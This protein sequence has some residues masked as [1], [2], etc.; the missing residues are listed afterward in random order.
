MENGTPAAPIVF[1]DCWR[2]WIIW[3]NG[4]GLLSSLPKFATGK[5]V[6]CPNEP[7]ISFSLFLFWLPG[8]AS[9]QSFNFQMSGAPGSMAELTGHT[10]ILI[11]SSLT[12]DW[13]SA[14]EKFDQKEYA[15]LSG[16]QWPGK[17]TRGRFAYW[18][19]LEIDTRALSGPVE[20]VLG[21]VR[22]D[23]V[24]CFLLDETGLVQEEM[25][26]SR[27]TNP[28]LQ[29]RLPI[30]HRGDVPLTFLPGKKYRLLV[31]LRTWMSF[32]TNVRPALYNPTYRSRSLGEQLPFYFA[33]HGLFFGTLI[34]MVGYSTVQYFQ[35]RD[36]SFLWYA[37]YLA[38][39]FVFYLREFNGYNPFFKILPDFVFGQPWYM[40]FSFGQYFFYVIF[41]NVF[42]GSKKR[43]PN[44]YRFS[45]MLIIAMLVFLVIERIL[46]HTNEVW[47]WKATI[48]AR[49]IFLFG[50]LY[51][52]GLLMKSLDRL[53]LFI[54]SG[55]MILMLSNLA[56]IILSF[57]KS[58]MWGF[59]DYTHIPSYLGILLEIFLFSTG[60]GYKPRQ[61]EAQKAEAEV[62]ARRL[63]ELG[64]AKSRFFTNLTHEFRTPLTVI[65]GLASEM[66]ARPNFKFAERMGILKRNGREM[67]AL[68]NQLL[69]L[70]RAE[71]GRPVLRPVRDDVIGFLQL[72]VDSFHSHAL[73]Q[74]V[75]L[76]FY[77]EN[78]RLEMDFDPAKMQHI[79]TNLLSNAI[80]FTPEYGKV[81][82]AAKQVVLPQGEWLEIK[83][84]D[85]GVGIS[86]AELPHIFD[87]FYQVENMQAKAGQ[88]T[89]IG[90]ALVQGLVQAMEGEVTVKSTA[91]KG[92]TFVVRLPITR[93][94]PAPNAPLQLPDVAVAERVM[95]PP[96]PAP[97]SV[98]FAAA[99]RSIVLVIE[100]NAEVDYYLRTC[101]E[102]DWEVHTVTR[103]GHGV[104]K[105][106]E[107]LPDVII[108]D[109]MMPGMDGFEVCE[110][111]KSDERTS[112]IPILLLTAKATAADKLEG[113][114]KG[115]DAY[116]LKP[117]DKKEL[118]LRL[119]NFAKLGHN[120]NRHADA[121]AEGEAVSP[122][123]EF[124]EK[125]KQAIHA[126]LDDTNF[127]NDGL[128]RT[129][130]VSRA[131]MH[132]KMK[133]LTGLSTGRFIREYR[134]EQARQLLEDTDLRIGEVARKTGFE[135]LSWFTQAYRE[136]FG[137]SPS[138]TR[139]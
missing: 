114:S 10:A 112:H 47:A 27:I 60:L 50:G 131:Q 115:A 127:G 25:T 8:F 89:G 16:F 68:V 135:N 108:C 120:I 94:A 29:S 139:K 103:G 95:P 123:S 42:L 93:K 118:L 76:Q 132:R 82:V 22:K 48:S 67:L 64:R 44:F 98:H 130:G 73:S 19:A 128:C 85:T 14:S 52:L 124:M 11:D 57:N 107:I 31:R 63:S 81:L 126:N 116:L 133:A 18:L 88:G 30:V 121:M 13:Q 72:L 71:V 3:P 122:E 129:V 49:L 26:G 41:V 113:L 105:A 32:S 74:K 43:L 20:L 102:P 61:L 79:V 36:A 110:K 53:G 33:F 97:Q 34:F 9:A 138:E 84:K 109:V 125:V 1:R 101:L 75:G 77:S 65:L 117:F 83:V 7:R 17:F 12:F 136:A 55:T 100:D 134:L 35:N 38:S 24:H 87:R 51:F 4:Y 137:Q 2:S 37:C 70:S 66:E 46:V 62:E 90:L 54:I 58:Q 56:V 39:I 21:G 69:E 15:P 91:G 78:E 99:G 119:E 111:L 5:T 104:E 106:F 6:S 45:R 59:W 92:A 80:K 96:R 86:E 40:V 28:D 23:T